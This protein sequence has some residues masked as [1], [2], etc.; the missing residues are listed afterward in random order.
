MNQNDRELMERYLYEVTRRLP[1]KQRQEVSLELQELI[2]DMVENGQSIDEV[3]TRLGDPKEFAKQYQDGRHYLIGPEYFDTYLWFV[4][5]VL[6][7]AGVTL[8][9]VS[10]VEGIQEGLGITGASQPQAAVTAAILGIVRGLGS[11]ISAC[12]GA[13]GGI[14]LLFAIL[15]RRNISLDGTE[16]RA[17]SPGD[18]GKGPAGKGTHWRP[19]SLAPLPHEKALIRRGDSIAGI[20]FILIF[21]LLLIFAP[22]LFGAFFRQGEEIV[23]IP[24]FNLEQWSLILPVFI[25]WLV[26]GL[27][28]EVFQLVTGR[29]CRA[30]MICNILCNLV[31][32]ILAFLVLKVFPFW[33][34][35]FAV[36]LKAQLGGAENEAANFFLHHWDGDL[37]SNLLLAFLVLVSLAEIATTVYHT[38]R[39]G[40]RPKEALK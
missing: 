28:D 29:Y 25:L 16:H 40:N 19:D 22:Q 8:L 24:I 32:T 6:I 38:L 34:P 30:V 2:G 17:W 7:C 18:L 37:A 33:N 20:V 1:K 35:E 11:A 12:I 5:V 9:V 10:A 14:T 15:E 26:V 39:Y 21:A 31:Q 27:G 3:L 36:Q 23:T 13:F 4:R